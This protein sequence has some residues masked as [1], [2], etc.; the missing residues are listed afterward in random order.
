MLVSFLALRPCGPRVPLGRSRWSGLDI[1]DHSN[2]TCVLTNVKEHKPTPR[3][4]KPIR[5][6]R[7]RMSTLGDL[8]A[9]EPVSDLV[10][11]VAESA[12]IC[13]YPDD[14]LVASVTPQDG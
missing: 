9:G 13:R 4:R 11:G 6:Q 12:V 2:F 7:V 5:P 14:R 1:V 10:P 3:S 8:A